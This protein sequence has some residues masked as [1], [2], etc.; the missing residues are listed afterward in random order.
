MI[1]VAEAIS[2]CLGIFQKIFLNLF[3]EIDLTSFFFGLPWH[4]GLEENFKNPGK[5]TRDMK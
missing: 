3:R 4:S 1:I 5:E 2:V